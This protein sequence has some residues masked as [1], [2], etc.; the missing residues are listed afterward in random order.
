MVLRPALREASP[1]P[2]RAVADRS[3]TPHTRRMVEEEP[4]SP[5]SNWSDREPADHGRA[6]RFQDEELKETRPAAKGKGDKG[7][8]G[9]KGMKGKTAGKG[10]S[11]GAKAAGKGG[12]RD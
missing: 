11:K 5:V 8:G 3:P 9:K 10:K 1:S 2:R 6:V 7:K 12:K 4:H